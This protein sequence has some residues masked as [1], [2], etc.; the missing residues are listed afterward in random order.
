M[1][2]QFDKVLWSY[3]IMDMTCR[4]PSGSTPE[5]AMKNAGNCVKSQ[6]RESS[7][8][9][10]YHG[11]VLHYKEDQDEVVILSHNDGFSDPFIWTGN[12]ADYFKI[13]DID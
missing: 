13:W 10:K 4:T 8:F 3:K 6:E 5:E 1:A 9:P 2:F 12:T 11:R 7:G